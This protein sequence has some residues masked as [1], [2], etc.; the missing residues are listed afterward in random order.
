MLLQK[1]IP[2][3]KKHFKDYLKNPTTENFFCTSTTPEEITDIIKTLKSSKSVGPFSIPTKFLKIAKQELNI[4]LAELIN[5]FFSQ[6]TFPN[7]CKLANV[8]P[9]VRLLCNNY[10]PIS[11][12]SNIG[13]TIE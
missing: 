1:Q 6:G 12:L 10:R 8:I 3:I 9:I 2:P 13:N 11:L 4:P 5:K 7:T